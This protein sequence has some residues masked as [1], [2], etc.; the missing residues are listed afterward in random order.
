MLVLVEPSGPINIGS[1]ARLCKNF[2]VDEL[3]IVNPRCDLND[4]NALKMSVKGKN[5]LQ[6]AGIYSSL[7]DAIKDCN[8]VIATCGRLDHGEIPINSMEE[9]FPLIQE[10]SFETFAIVFGREDRGLTNNELQLANKVITI[11]TSK[12]YPSLN[13][14]HAV[15][16]VLSGLEHIN[17]TNKKEKV[18]TNKNRPLDKIA[19]A[20]ELNECTEDIER[21]LLNIG[22]LLQHT[23]NAR[24]NKVKLI[25]HRAEVRAKEVAL[26]RGI[27]HQVRWAIKSKH[28]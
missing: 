28:F 27:L 21:L 13:L 14:S 25:L 11:E 26:I 18:N 5:I 22:F 19:S 23:A 7:I 10:N 4:P 12:E 20:S 2:D 15:A 6:N 1:I 8:F 3:R 16:I 9:V 17:N 24:M